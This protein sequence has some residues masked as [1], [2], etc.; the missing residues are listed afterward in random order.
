MPTNLN[1]FFHVLEHLCSSLSV[2]VVR[3]LLN[4]VSVTDWRVR[5]RTPLL[6]VLR[7][8]PPGAGL[9]ARRSQLSGRF[10]NLTRIGPLH[11]LSSYG[12]SAIANCST[13]EHVAVGNS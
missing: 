11:Y 13:N 12:N 7:R 8:P 3:V 10:M 5:S 2:T 4:Q 1:P 6:I 9:L